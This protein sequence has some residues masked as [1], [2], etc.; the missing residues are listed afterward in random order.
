MFPG[1][2]KGWD[3]SSLAASKLKTGSPLVWQEA[4][5]TI[6]K[7]SVSFSLATKGILR[8]RPRLATGS[9]RT[10]FSFSPMGVSVDV[11]KLVFR[12]GQTREG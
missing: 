10:S 5:E 6:A 3:L 9:I 2:A 7:T 11:P 4:F 1:N 8:D 12:E